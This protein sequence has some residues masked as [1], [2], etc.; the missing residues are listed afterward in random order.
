MCEK[1]QTEGIGKMKTA[2]IDTEQIKAGV[3]LRELAGRYTAL[4]RESAAELA[5]PCPKCGGD[6][7][8]HVKAGWAFC[9]VCWPKGGDA[10]AF[11]QW[12]GLAGDFQTACEVLTGR[13]GLPVS[14]AKQTPNKDKTENRQTLQN[15]AAI[16]TAA[17][18][19]LA[20]PEGAA[21]RAYLEGRGLYSEVWEAFG[22]GYR[23]AGKTGIAP[24]PAICIPWALSSGRIVAIRYRFVTPH[25]DGKHTTKLVAETGSRF[26]GHLFGGCALSGPDK[27]A[28]L[29]ICEGELNAMSVWQATAG[30]VDALSLGSEGQ[31][32]P[33]AA[34]DALC[35]YR[36]IVVW[37][38]KP[39]IARQ[40]L[41]AL[42]GAVGFASPGG[43]D[44]NNWLQ[45][46]RLAEIVE[47]LQNGKGAGQ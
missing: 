41:Q 18:A 11:V 23:L 39:E 17:A 37:V 4:R 2:T 47:A 42:P 43:L 1:L 9:R 46:G 14:S 34:V 24:R 28:G 15:A 36:R 45:A 40:L 7:R 13:A 3:D 19:A 38:D 44:A 31:R 8:F 29:V 12:L 26:S 32:I 5:G 20:G 35:G 22:L 27:A 16:A 6:D 25:V 30:A 33:T 10:I 21:G